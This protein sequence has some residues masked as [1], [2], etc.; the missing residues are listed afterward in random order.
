M[1]PKRVTRRRFVASAVFILACVCCLY[2]QDP[3]GS[4]L[5]AQMG[6]KFTAIQ[7]TNED[8]IN[9]LSVLIN[10]QRQAA[11]KVL[12]EQI[13]DN[14]QTS[15][16]MLINRIKNGLEGY[17]NVEQQLALIF[18]ASLFVLAYVWRSERHENMRQQ[19]LDSLVSPVLYD[20]D[21]AV[22]AKKQSGGKQK[23]SVIDSYIKALGTPKSIV[24]SEKIGNVQYKV[25]TNRWTDAKQNQPG[26]V[27]SF[28]DAAFQNRF[29]QNTIQEASKGQK[30][31]KNMVGSMTD[32]CKMSEQ[33]KKVM[34]T[35]DEIAFHTNLLALNAAVEAARAGQHGKGFTVVAEEV[36]NLAARSAKAAKETAALRGYL[37]TIFL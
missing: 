12:H 30:Q 14:A 24:N 27:Q 6:G 19:I 17:V 23:I 7:K 22:S 25:H 4:S 37:E 26:A 13:D 29:T 36:R 18:S 5:F 2:V 16:Q 10:R 8:G 3:A 20:P 15:F 35:I 33:M 9:G 28:M 1:K 32:I 21:F 31:M 11:E 34:K